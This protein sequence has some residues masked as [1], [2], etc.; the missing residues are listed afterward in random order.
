VVGWVKEAGDIWHQIVIV[1]GSIYYVDGIIST[2]TIN[3]WIDLNNG[4]I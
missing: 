3:N 4:Y 2:P 1:N